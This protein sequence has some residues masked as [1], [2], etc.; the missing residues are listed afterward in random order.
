MQRQ[1]KCS[2]GLLQENGKAQASERPNR[3]MAKP[4]RNTRQHVE[5]P[6]GPIYVCGRELWKYH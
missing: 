3:I 5:A 4:I 6:L 2:E 1:P